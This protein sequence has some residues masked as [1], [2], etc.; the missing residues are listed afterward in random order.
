MKNLS[1][2]QKK[3]IYLAVILIGFLLL[4]LVFIYAP[5]SRRV[6]EIKNKLFFAENQI[7]EINKITQGQD[8]AAAVGKL[9]QKLVRLVRRMP[10]R[11][12][13]AMKFLTENARRL[14]IEVKNIVL[15]DKQIAANKAPGYIIGE[16]PIAMTL[17]A[18]YKA[19]GEYLIALDEDESLLTRVRELDIKGDG[20]GQP[21]LDVSLQ[22]SAYLSENQ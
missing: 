9:N 3:I 19:I 8:L 12:E 5:Q 1:K 17:T 13:V 22:I 15:L 20:E 18:D 10:E 2:E 7:T 11:Q 16:V 14:G 6:K 4:F 21:K